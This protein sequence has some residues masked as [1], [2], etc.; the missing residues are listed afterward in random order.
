MDRIQKA[1][2]RTTTE[3]GS[4]R[5]VLER[6]S[7]LIFTVVMAWF[8]SLAMEPAVSRLARRMPRGAAT[9]VVMAAYLLWSQWERVALAYG[10][11]LGAAVGAVVLLALLLPIAGGVLLS[12]VED[13]D[14]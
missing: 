14:Y 9:G 7:S 3:W 2:D 8:A 1:P 5:F 11:P 10:S 6:G 4:V 13:I 12:Q